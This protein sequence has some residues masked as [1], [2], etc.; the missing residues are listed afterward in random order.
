MHESDEM[1]KASK[2]II[3]ELKSLLREHYGDPGYA[4]VVGEGVSGDI[5]RRIDLMA[6]EYVVDAFSKSGLNIWVVS[7]EKG[8]YRLR[9]NPDYIVLLDPLDGSLNYVSQIP[10]A[11]ISMT[12][13]TVNRPRSPPLIHEAI[14]GVIA[15]VFNNIQI[16]YIDSKIIYG[17]KVYEK[18]VSNNGRQ[19]RIISAYFNR[20]EE[21]SVIR[22]IVINQGE[23][24]KLRIMGSASIESTLA[25]LGLIDYFI[26]LTGRLRN[27]DVALAIVAAVK[28]GSSI[29][30]EPP[31]NHIRVDKVE[32]I[33]RLAIG[34]SNDSIIN[35]IRRKWFTS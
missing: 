28:L 34:P 15:D 17:N 31:L 25:S 9:E 20:V 4:T 21:F 12:L 22:D 10:F 18:R 8:L 19:H 1:I 23:G 3:D 6:E 14:Y 30:V 33:R 7:E 24:F 5:T 16:E 29:L 11:S 2:K 32:I 13:Y 26:S 35:E 27:T